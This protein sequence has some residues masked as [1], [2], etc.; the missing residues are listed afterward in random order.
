MP[1]TLER[2]L[3]RVAKS[4]GYSKERTDRYVYGTQANINRR[5]KGRWRRA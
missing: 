5:R 3:R 4:R 2:K 1:K